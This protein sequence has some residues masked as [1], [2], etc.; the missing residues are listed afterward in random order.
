MTVAV[1]EKEP[2]V[3]DLKQQLVVVVAGALACTMAMGATSGVALAATTD[4]PAYHTDGTIRCIQS[5]GTNPARIEIDPP[6]IY[7][8][9]GGN[10]YVFW[11]AWVYESSQENTGWVNWGDPTSSTPAPSAWQWYL[12]SPTGPVSAPGTITIANPDFDAPG[13]VTYRAPSRALGG[14]YYVYFQYYWMP[15][16]SSERWVYDGELAG[17][18][19]WAENYWNLGGI[20]PSQGTDCDFS[21]QL[22]TVTGPFDN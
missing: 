18:P 14:Q 22:I 19:G 21:R 7:A 16:S 8:L 20:L 3:R 11:N 6:T 1:N 9:P 4:T 12:T 17:R 5:D 15:R 2:P 10:Q 13:A